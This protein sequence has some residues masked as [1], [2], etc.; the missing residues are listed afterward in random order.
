[1]TPP[2]ARVYNS[3][4]EGGHDMPEQRA[5]DEVDVR[6]RHKTSIPGL[7]RRHV[8]SIRVYWDDKPPTDISRERL[9]GIFKALRLGFAEMEKGPVE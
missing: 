2:R 5:N 8:S 3:E 1:M 6:R 7:N 9:A 4:S